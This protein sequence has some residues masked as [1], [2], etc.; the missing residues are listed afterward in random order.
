MTGVLVVLVTSH[1][2]IAAG[3]YALG[4]TERSES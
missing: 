2:T 3:F 1:A 4:R